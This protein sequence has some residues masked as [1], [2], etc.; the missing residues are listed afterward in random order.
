M[1]VIRTYDTGAFPFRDEIAKLLA[2]PSGDLDRVHQ[3][4]RDL[5]P[6][7]PLTHTTETRTKFH[8]VILN[9]V[10]Y[11]G[12]VVRGIYRK[13]IEDVTAPLIGRNF[14]YQAFPTFRLQLPG[15]MAIHQ[16]HYDSDPDHRH[17]EWEINFQIALTDMR[18]SRATWIES[19]PGLRDFAPIEMGLGQFAI[20]DG[21]RCLHGN[22][23]NETGLTRVS[24]DFRV[25]PWDRY[26]AHAVAGLSA[27]AGKRFT[28]GEYYEQFGS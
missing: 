15:E 12:S 1:P 28:V 4:R 6:D 9:D 7:G 11:D 16:W 26:A 20:F 2:V 3:I 14:A 5:M 24:L 27:N 21:N 22:Q 25:I 19:V 13:F 17:P 10:L 23:T 18:G 8:E